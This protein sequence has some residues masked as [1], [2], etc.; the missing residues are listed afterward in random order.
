VKKAII[1][2]V[3]GQDGSY[4]SRLLLEKNYEVHGLRRRSS[5]FNT[6]RIDDL[7]RKKNPLI[8]LHYCDLTDSS[9]IIRLVQLIQP[10][11]IY[12]LG[13]MSHVHISFDIP[14]YTANVDGLGTLR[15]LEAV[16]ILGLK[17]KIY[18]A[19][20]S[21]LY[22]LVQEMP[23]TEKSP[24]YPRSPYGV[25]KLYGYWITINYREAYN[26]YAC[27]GI[28]FNH[29]SP[30]RGE[31]FVTRKITLSAVNIALGKEDTIYLGNL[32][33]QRDWGHAK[34]YVEG[35]W[36][37]LQQEKPT[38]Y[39]LA[40]GITTTVRD[41]VKKTFLVLGI[42]IYFEGKDQYEVGKVKRCNGE[43]KLEIDKEVVKVNEKYFRPTEVDLLVGDPTKAKK[44]LNW[45]PKYD[46][47]SLINEMVQADL[48]KLSN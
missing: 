46:L 42:E 38:D 25:A 40:T 2:G 10:D 39:V 9:N 29:E 41:F 43:Y 24:F 7:I 31:T 28:L 13:A 32:N 11:E 6:E 47:D 5:I 12:N 19:S 45:V 27:N 4:L 37:I 17:T 34:D 16:R 48:I 33:A 36:L 8:K 3:N 14:E 1:I 35:M 23:Q 26:I 15:V 22:G 30:L 21:E 44:E 20:T 18:Q